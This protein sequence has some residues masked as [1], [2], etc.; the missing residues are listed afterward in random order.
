M[1]KRKPKT[2]FKAPKPKKPSAKKPAKKTK[3]AA[4]WYKDSGKTA[5]T[6]PGEYPRG[7][8]KKVGKYTSPGV[9]KANLIRWKRK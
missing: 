9:P 5:I 8:Y 7:T 3:T 4:I 1:I 2:S 6:S